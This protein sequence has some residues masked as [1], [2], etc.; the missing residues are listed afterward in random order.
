MT[1]NFDAKGKRDEVVSELEALTNMQL[2]TDPLGSDVRDLVT[3]Y[4]TRSADVDSSN[5]FV[6]SANG[7]AGSEEYSSLVSMNVSV[8]I[9]AKTVTPEKVGDKPE[10]EPEPGPEVTE[11]VMGSGAAREKDAEHPWSPT[12]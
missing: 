2:G 7:H 3:S 9:Q 10:S 5:Q 6:V 12:S 1:F 8:G 4:L 11:S